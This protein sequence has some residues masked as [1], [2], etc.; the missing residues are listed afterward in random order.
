MADFPPTEEQQQAR[1]AF[2][3][4]DDLVISAYAGSGKTATLTLLS[5][6]VPEDRV[7]FLAFNKSIATDAGKKFPS[8]TDCKTAH[9]HAYRAVGKNYQDRL[10]GPRIYAKAHANILG[11]R[12][13]LEFSEDVVLSPYNL[14]VKV[15]ETVRNFCFSAEQEPDWMHVPFVP[16][17][18]MAV[19]RAYIVPLARKMWADK[20]MPRGKCA[21]THDDYFKIWSLSEPHLPYDAIMVDEAQDSNPAL[22][23]V[24]RGQRHAQK[25]L[26]GDSNQQ[27]YAWRGAV[28]AMTDFPAKHRVNLTK[29][30]RFGQAVADEAN[31]WLKLLGNEVPLQ[32]FEKIDSKL[33]VLMDDAD[34]ILCR[35][36]AEAIS[37]AM[38]A[39]TSGRSYSI[40]GGTEEIKKFAESAL[41][42]MN[43]STY[44]VKHPDLIAFKTW[45]QVKEFV[46]AEGGDMKVLVRLIEEYTPE[47]IIKV[48]D[49]AVPEPR[50]DV[51][52]STAHKAKGREWNRV[53]IGSDF[54]EPVNEDGTD[55]ELNRSEMMLAYVSVTRAQLVLDNEGLA[56]V[57]RWLNKT[58]EAEET[59]A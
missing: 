43:G 22:I 17:A 23:S 19:L 51:T 32:G 38:M 48:A 58:T 37:Q 39:G 4:G 18:D 46:E 31:K 52:I 12:S 54:K 45:T 50:G 33:G 47:T 57:D 44:G 25:V 27:I 15:A 41:S 6:D 9:S 24:V 10:N 42:L 8:N 35:T 16:G 28:D 14:A 55:G 36:N 3:T 11:I 13:A 40:V 21:F 53:K 5:E 49:E 29:S 2:A 7:G 59:P 26:V 1:D 34:A 20:Q 30:F 56:W